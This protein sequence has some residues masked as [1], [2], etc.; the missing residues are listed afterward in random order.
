MKNSTDK[1]QQIK[2]RTP[3]NPAMPLLGIYPKE[4]KTLI[5]SNRLCINLDGWD[6]EGDGSEVLKGEDICIP[7]ADLCSGLTEN[8]KFL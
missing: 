6:V 4:T 7:M 1:P 2:N 8:N 3:Y 5:N